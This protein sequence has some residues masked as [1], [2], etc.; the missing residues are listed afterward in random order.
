MNYVSKA[1]LEGGN[2]CDV[3]FQ[4]SKRYSY[5]KRGKPEGNLEMNL[6][7]PPEADASQNKERILC[8]CPT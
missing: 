1:I 5:M 4:T 6:R 8:C 3:R 7:N 2:I